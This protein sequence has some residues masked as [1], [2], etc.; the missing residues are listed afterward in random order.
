[1]QTLVDSLAE[2]RRRHLQGIERLSIQDLKD[3]VAL[4]F[5]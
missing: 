2:D 4:I 5:E 1:M 3:M